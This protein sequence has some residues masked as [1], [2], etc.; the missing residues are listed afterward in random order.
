[1]HTVMLEMDDSVY[2][3]VMS[4][5]ER[6]P[7]DKI[8]VEENSFPAISEEE[9]RQ[10]VARALQSADEGNGQPIDLVFDRIH[11]A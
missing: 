10:K 4:L 1:M 5:I 6:L 8:R 3:Q 11:R 2:D 7:K 9:A